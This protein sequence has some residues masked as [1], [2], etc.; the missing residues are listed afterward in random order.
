VIF[1]AKKHE[2]Y[3]VIFNLKSVQTG[4]GSYKAEVE[5]RAGSG[6][7]TFLKPE[8]E[9]ELK[10]IVPAPQHFIRVCEYVCVYLYDS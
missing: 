2:K 8:L 7:K 10:Q 1:F 3:T 5:A 9:L 4:T 6:D